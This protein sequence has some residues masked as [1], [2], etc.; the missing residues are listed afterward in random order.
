MCIIDL[1]VSYVWGARTQRNSVGNRSATNTYIFI[2]MYTYTKNI[3]VCTYSYYPFFP[4]TLP[5]SS[6]PRLRRHHNI[7]PAATPPLA[8]SL[9]PNVPVAARCTAAAVVD[10]NDYRQLWV[11][12]ISR[13]CCAHPRIR[14]IYFRMR[15]PRCGFNIEKLPSASPFAAAAVHDFP[16]TILIATRPTSNRWINRKRIVPVR[17]L[18]REKHSDL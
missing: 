6:A 1:F 15:S 9:S 16:P 11:F 10:Y 13:Y 17:W 2:L 3:M 14:V 8:P 4:L 5:P 12:G 7:F 18:P